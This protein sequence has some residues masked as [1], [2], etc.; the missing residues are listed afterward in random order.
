MRKSLLLVLLV[1]LANAAP[2]IADTN[3]PP[4]PKC[5]AGNCL[6]P[7]F[8]VQFPHTGSATTAAGVRFPLPLHYY[9]ANLYGAVGTADLAAERALTAGTDYEPVATKK[10]RGLGA[11]LMA[12]YVDDDLGPYHEAMVAFPVRQG[13]PAV[14]SDDP[15]AMV[16]ALFDPS[17]QVWGVRLILDRQLPIDAG[18]EHFGIPKVPTP[19]S[20]P[21]AI[22]PSHTAF[23]F[24]EPDG[25]PITSGD[26]VL[27]PKRMAG[28]ASDLATQPGAVGAVA[29]TATRSYLHLRFVYRD[30]RNLPALKFAEVAGRVGAGAHVAIA[31]FDARS[32]ITTNADAPFGS[33]LAALDL[34]PAVS[35][36]L[37]NL[38]LVL[39]GH[40]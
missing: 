32:H 7:L 5:E 37:E 24:R 33:D 28:S 14:V 10:G 31:P 4:P 18:R 15:G 22:T 3:S 30:I 40:L 6:D 27:A 34:H 25:T 35:V 19:E 13:A 12:N 11:L 1:A 8:T 17:N 36:V 23:D 39:D 38:H 29:H 26:V 21:L 9:D 20:M 16:A 2:A